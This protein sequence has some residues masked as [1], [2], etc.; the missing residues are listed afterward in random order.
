MKKR[1]L[2]FFVITFSAVCALVFNAFYKEAK[3]TAL[4]KLNDEQVVHA[5]QAALGIE[6]FFRTWT[7]ILTSFAKIDD[8]I[9]TDAAGKRY[10]KFFYEAHQEEIRSITRMDEGGTII[11]TVPFSRVIGSNISEQKHVQEILKK[12]K[13]VISDVFKTVQGFDAVALHVPVFK[14]AVFKGTIAIV[15]NFESLA[16]RYLDVIKIRV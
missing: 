7:G 1:T 10:I 11:Y 2:V 3:N 6:D 14:G 4:K 15:I 12:H 8:I 5:R 9:N 13:P 16:K